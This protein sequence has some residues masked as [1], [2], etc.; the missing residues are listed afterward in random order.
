MDVAEIA[1]VS[2]TT[3]S[4]VISG[5]RDKDVRITEETRKK[6]WDAARALGYQPISAAQT[7]RSQRSNMVVLMVPD[8]INL[9]YPYLETAVQRE[10]E[11]AGVDVFIY[12]THDELQRE[13]D[14]VDVLLRRGV[15]G[16]ITQTFR[17]SEEDIGRL[18]DAGIAVVIHGNE[19]THPYADN[20]ML[21]EAKAVEEAVSYLIDQGHRRIGALAGPDTMWTGRLRK[22]GYI[23]ALVSHH[24]PID[25]R[26]IYETDYTRESGAAG[27]A[28]FLSLPEPP[29]AIF[30]AD[31]LLAIGGM[32]YALDA[33][34]SVPEDVA[35]VGFDDVPEATIVRPRLTTIHKNVELGGTAAV[36]ML[37]ER[38]DSGYLIPSRQE[39]VGYEIVQRESA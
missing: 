39:V 38:L 15:D 22:A 23:N 31:D 9:Y 7:L 25:D 18:V 26:L 13:R 36:R 4:Y 19:P 6:V 17:L 8:I 16:V 29:T 2:R 27:M 11:K 3:V 34:L 14:F 30:A 37:F 10:A 20:V 5:R 28:H 12:N 35:F 32:L 21:D 33:G 1:G 24:I